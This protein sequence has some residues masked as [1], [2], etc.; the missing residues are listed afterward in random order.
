MELL[1]ENLFIVVIKV[2]QIFALLG[3]GTKK[4]VDSV[5]LVHLF[6]VR[7]RFFLKLLYHSIFI[8]FN[9]LMAHTSP[10]QKR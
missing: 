3:D 2:L 10:F 7:F 9:P 8:V 6:L 5:L 1:L 4:I